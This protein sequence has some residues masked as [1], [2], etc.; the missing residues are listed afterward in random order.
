MS[1][2]DLAPN[3]EESNDQ[4][5]APEALSRRIDLPERRFQPQAH[6]IELF[7]KKETETKTAPELPR[8]KE[9][10]EGTSPI[11]AL[12]NEMD[13]A[14]KAIAEKQHEAELR[15][16]QDM[17]RMLLRQKREQNPGDL[18]AE[19]LEIDTEATTE[20]TLDRRHEVL[21]HQAVQPKTEIRITSEPASLENQPVPISQILSSHATNQLQ[22]SDMTREEV[23]SNLP[24]NSVSM[25]KKSLQIGFFVGVGV[26]TMGIIVY[27]I[28]S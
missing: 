10:Y 3:D 5:K 16:N 25:Y 24:N 26:I 23:P 22:E 28:F 21:D 2:Y 7:T 18:Q 13:E 15:Q 27:S 12:E 9:T 19:D 1:K 20:R 4:A 6:L 11:V 17:Q 8:Q 14:R